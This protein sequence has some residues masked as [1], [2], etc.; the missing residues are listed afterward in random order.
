MEDGDSVEQRPGV[1]RQREDFEHVLA[2]VDA[3]DSQSQF[4][5]RMHDLVECVDR[6]RWWTDDESDV[7]ASAIILTREVQGLIQKFQVYSYVER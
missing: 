3:I 4:S 7:L 5:K 6:P 1:E 2:I